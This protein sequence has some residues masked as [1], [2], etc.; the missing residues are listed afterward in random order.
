MRPAH[1][2]PDVAG[3]PETIAWVGDLPGHVRLVDQTRLPATVAFCERTSLDDLITDIQR[4]AV[5]GAPAIG[6]AGG[7][8]MVLAAQASTAT[9][10]AGV[11]A[12]VR[13]AAP[14]IAAARPTAVNLSWAV[15]R[16]LQHATTLTS[17]TADA[18]RA[19]LLAAARAIHD[20]DR[21]TCRS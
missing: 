17:G 2:N 15:D 1:E 6:V 10:G 5:R 11:V 14:R 21:A 9:D 8:A 3:L 18:A 16:L 19:S 7:Y 20:A 13:A 4:L 12:D